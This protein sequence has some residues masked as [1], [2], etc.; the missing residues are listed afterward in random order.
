MTCLIEVD[1]GPGSASR[2]Y[3]A[4]RR[5]QE[6]EV[7][8]LLHVI[9]S[10]RAAVVEAGQRVLREA[11]RTLHRL[12]RRLNIE[13]RLEIGEA[14][15]RIVSVADAIG[16]DLI[17]VAAHGEGDFPYL[18]RLGRT[19]RGALEQGH[20][21]VLLVSPHETQLYRPHP[22]ACRRTPAIPHVPS[23]RG[24]ASSSLQTSPAP[25]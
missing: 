11:A 20:R 25:L 6:C 19:A 4:A 3:H 12:D 13:A 8:C 2:L 15:E 24:G 14:A 22:G 23:A 5:I 1:R 7:V 18:T 9:P 17:V 16:A 10:G 21:P